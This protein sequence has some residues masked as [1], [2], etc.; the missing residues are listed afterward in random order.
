M[1]LPLKQ[2]FYEFRDTESVNCWPQVHHIIDQVYLSDDWYSAGAVHQGLDV[3]DSQAN[4]EVHDDDGEK[5]DVG[6][7]VV[8]EM[9]KTFTVYNLY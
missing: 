3:T 1:Q 7:G 4:Q 5:N 6:S 8:P 2:L 9:S